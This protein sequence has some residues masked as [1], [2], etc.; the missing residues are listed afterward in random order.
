MNFLKGKQTRSFFLVP[1]SLI[2][3]IEAICKTLLT[4]PKLYHCDDGKLKLRFTFKK[5]NLLYLASRVS[6]FIVFTKT[7]PQSN[8]I[9]ASNKLMASGTIFTANYYYNVNW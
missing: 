5:L 8:Y 4:F 1:E 7:L 6:C 3:R 9:K 2:S